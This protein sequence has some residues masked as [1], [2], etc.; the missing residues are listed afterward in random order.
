MRR[1]MDEPENAAWFGNLYIA[2]FAHTLL[3]LG[4]PRHRPDERLA[5][6][7]LTQTTDD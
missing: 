7:L 1:A 4:Q 3:R 2:A 5:A 6:A